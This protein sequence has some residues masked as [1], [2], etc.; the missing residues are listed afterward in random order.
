MR[1]LV[2]PA[3]FK[4]VLTAAQ[5]AEALAEGVRAAGHWALVQPL[6]DG[7][8]GTLDAVLA[9]GGERRAARVCGP[10]GGSVDA[11]WALL[12]GAVAVVEMAQASGLALA[13]PLPRDLAAATSYGTGQLVAAAR[14]AGARKLI[15]GIGGSATNDGG[16]GALRALGARFWGADG[17]EITGA[18][19][20]ERLERIDGF[21]WDLETIAA[22]DVDNPLTGPAGATRVFGPQKG[23]TPAA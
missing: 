2:C 17:G 3:P 8:E 7:G 16:L 12:P 23:G 5:A 14:E 1:V 10:Y 15:V 13:G 4:G 6:A 11:G 18:E 19:G 20:L 22:C 21:A 9:R